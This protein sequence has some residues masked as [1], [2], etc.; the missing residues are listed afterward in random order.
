[1]SALLQKFRSATS[2]ILLGIPATALV[3]WQLLRGR[4]PSCGSSSHSRRKETS[5][6]T[7]SQTSKRPAPA[8]LKLG[9]QEIDWVGT[10]RHRREI[11]H[12]HL[13][14]NLVDD[15]LKS[16]QSFQRNL[17]I[18]VNICENELLTSNLIPRSQICKTLSAMEILVSAFEFASCPRAPRSALYSRERIVLMLPIDSGVQKIVR[19]R[20]RLV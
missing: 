16:V 1:M 12:N 13:M 11:R 15:E 10:H 3:E 9:S 6:S 18:C 17:L 8:H 19:S 14:T 7:S 20:I 5:R 2:P 4:N